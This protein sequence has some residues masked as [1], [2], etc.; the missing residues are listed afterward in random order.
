[1]SK[2]LTVVALYYQVRSSIGTSNLFTVSIY[3]NNL[4]RISTFLQTENISTIVTILYDEPAEHQSSCHL[5]IHYK[6]KRPR[7]EPTS[8]K[9]D[10]CQPF[11]SVI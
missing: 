5:H 2:A 8:R 7:M 4:Y 6:K 9:A 3:R 11:A 1:M 10:S